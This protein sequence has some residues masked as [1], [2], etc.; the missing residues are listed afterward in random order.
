MDIIIYIYIGMPELSAFNIETIS[1]CLH[2]FRI[3]ASEEDIQSS[4]LQ[5][6]NHLFPPTENDNRNNN[7]NNNEEEE[8]V[9]DDNSTYSDS[10][11]THGYDGED[12]L[13][14]EDER[15]RTIPTQ[16]S[17]DSLSINQE[18]Q[19]Q[20]LHH[21]QSKYK[22]ENQKQSKNQQL[23]LKELESIEIQNILSQMESLIATTTTTT[24]ANLDSNHRI[25]TSTTATNNYETA[26]PTTRFDHHSFEQ[27]EEE[28]EEEET[29]GTSRNHHHHIHTI[30]QQIDE[31]FITLLLINYCC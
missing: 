13:S 14:I 31:M 8:E 22:N 12:L 20:N 10:Q 28:E 25:S 24:T 23:Q 21:D 5:S 26:S 4:I 17:F 1:R 11:I 7:N 3:W 16:N 29:R 9:D 6:T 2:R 27:I 18:K 19:D 15:Q 30:K